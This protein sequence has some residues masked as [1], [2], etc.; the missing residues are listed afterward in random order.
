[1]FHCV[2]EG[3]EEMFLPSRFHVTA[4]TVGEDDNAIS[5]IFL[6]WKLNPSLWHTDIYISALFSGIC[7]GYTVITKDFLYQQYKDRRNNY[8][9]QTN[10]MLICLRYIII[11]QCT[12]HKTQTEEIVSSTYILILSFR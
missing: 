10:K 7:K 8:L 11:S 4:L 2:S 6:H 9:T 5:P 3:K 12:V 1:M